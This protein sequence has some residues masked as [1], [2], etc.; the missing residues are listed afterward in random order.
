MDAP[1]SC[2]LPVTEI[3]SA[4]TMLDKN[5]LIKYDKR[6]GQVQAGLDGLDGPMDDLHLLQPR[7]T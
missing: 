4:L 5:N 6:T 2:R 3:H 1:S 7:L